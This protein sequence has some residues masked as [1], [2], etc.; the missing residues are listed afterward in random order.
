MSQ[1]VPLLPT[2]DRCCPM[3][4]FHALAAAGDLIDELRSLG[5]HEAASAADA[6]VRW[7]AHLAADPAVDHE[8]AQRDPEVAELLR[9]EQREL[10]DALAERDVSFIV[11]PVGASQGTPAPTSPV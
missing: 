11:T 2:G 7:L 3:T 6:L 4:M 1:S 5:V 10:R 9:R 8:A